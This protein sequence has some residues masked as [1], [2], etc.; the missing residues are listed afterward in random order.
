[1]TVPLW[2][3]EVP[4]SVVSTMHVTPSLRLRRMADFAGPVV[5]AI[6]QLLPAFIGQYTISF[7]C[8]AHILLG[9]SSL[10]A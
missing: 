6:R 8:G 7:S 10:I 2:Q 1:M 3:N 4:M 5:V 9:L